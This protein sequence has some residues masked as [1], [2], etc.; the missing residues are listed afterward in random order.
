M[1]PGCSRVTRSRLHNIP[2][3]SMLRNCGRGQAVRF[4]HGLLIKCS[5]G[6]VDTVFLGVR[7]QGFQAVFFVLGS[8]FSV[9]IRH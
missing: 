9:V 3:A 5:R 4:L 6:I 8:G 2:R 1:G 7:G